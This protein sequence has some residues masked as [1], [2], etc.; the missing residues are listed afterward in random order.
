MCADSAQSHAALAHGLR[1]SQEPSVHQSYPAQCWMLLQQQVLMLF[2]GGQ[3]QG[4]MQCG[5]GWFDY[6]VVGWARC[7][8]CVSQM[9]SYCTASSHGGFTS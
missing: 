1:Y 4:H 2:T 5:A 9:Q 8:A 3:S 7:Q 6:Q